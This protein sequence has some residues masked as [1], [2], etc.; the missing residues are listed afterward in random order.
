M[1]TRTKQYA[2]I[3][4]KYLTLSEYFLDYDDFGK[5]YC[6]YSRYIITSEE[7][8]KMVDPFRFFIQKS[9][10]YLTDKNNDLCEYVEKTDKDCKSLYDTMISRFKNLY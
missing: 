6:E 2:I 7:C 9:A 8:N 3:D 10:E 5:V 4:R 1:K